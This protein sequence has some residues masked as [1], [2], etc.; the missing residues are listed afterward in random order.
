MGPNEGRKG[1]YFA[2]D[3][4]GDVVD[5]KDVPFGSI[6]LPFETVMKARLVVIA[7]EIALMKAGMLIVVVES[8]IVE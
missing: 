3:C 7:V 4:A 8:I 2:C 1:G 5:A 6:D